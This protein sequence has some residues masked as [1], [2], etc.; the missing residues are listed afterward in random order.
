MARGTKMVKQM[1]L[2]TCS[3]LTMLSRVTLVVISSTPELVNS[4]PY[5]LHFTL[6]VGQKVDQT[7]FMTIKYVIYY[8]SLSFHSTGKS[9]CLI[10]IYT[11]LTAF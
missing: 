3:S 2:Y 1:F 9:W 10:N 8:V 6:V 4:L 11:N 7:S 5:I